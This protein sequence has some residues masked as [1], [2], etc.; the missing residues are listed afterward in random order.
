MGACVSRNCKRTSWKM[1][2]LGAEREPEAMEPFSSAPSD[3]PQRCKRGQAAGLLSPCHTPSSS[4]QCGRPA[5]LC[6]PPA[7]HSRCPCDLHILLCLPT[8]ALMVTLA[9][10]AVHCFLLLPVVLGFPRRLSLVVYHHNFHFG[11]TT[12]SSVPNPSRLPPPHPPSTLFDL[13]PQPPPQSLPVS[14]PAAW[15]PPWRGADPNACS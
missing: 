11:P 9:P 15:P 4:S 10:M 2:A 7:L 3:S 5:C 13:H 1:G 14:S 12:S 6:P 8:G